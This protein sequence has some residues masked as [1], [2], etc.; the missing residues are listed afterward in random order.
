MLDFKTSVYQ[1]DPLRNQI[2]KPQRGRRYLQFIH[3]TAHLSVEGLVFRRSGQI[4][5]WAL[6][7]RESVT[8]THLATVW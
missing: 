7:A 2:G 1:K 3:M 8:V 5:F 4:V 6:Q